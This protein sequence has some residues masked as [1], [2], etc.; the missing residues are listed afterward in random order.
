ML[1]GQTETSTTYRRKA[2]MKKN[3]L[4]VLVIEDNAKHL[5]DME[6]FVQTLGHKVASVLSATTYSEASA[7]LQVG[8]VDGVISDIHFPLCE[9]SM[10][11]QPEPIGVMVTVLCKERG[12]P[13]V[14]NTDGYHHGSRNEWICQMM[15]ELCLPSIV[16]ASNDY[17]KEA[18]TK[19]WKKAFESLFTE[20][21]K[22]SVS[23]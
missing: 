7:Y 19:N 10:W 14:L 3:Q 9:E 16:D 2:E 11:S 22:Q 18:E 21:E 20:I 8:K 13:C 17:N 12:I 5:E 23:R 4:T 15:R 1:Q 6:R